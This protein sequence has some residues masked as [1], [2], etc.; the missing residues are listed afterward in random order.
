MAQDACALTN[1]L[2]CRYRCRFC[3]GRG[4]ATRPWR[5]PP[6]EA[7][8]MATLRRLRACFRGVGPD[9]LFAFNKTHGTSEHNFIP[10]GPVR[11]PAGGTTSNEQ[12][13]DG[14]EEEGGRRRGSIQ[15]LVAVC[16]TSREHNSIVC[17]TV[18]WLQARATVCWSHG[19]LVLALTNTPAVHAAVARYRLQLRCLPAVVYMLLR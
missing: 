9:E 1:C 5:Q 4:G 16:W 8:H 11:L 15:A 3:A 14:E 12:D 10:D 6:P 13:Q 18:C 17:L 19:W 2:R 7:N